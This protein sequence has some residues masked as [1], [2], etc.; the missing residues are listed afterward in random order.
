MAKNHIKVDDETWRRLNSRKEPGD[1]FEEVI[2]RLLEEY[3]E[4]PAGQP[5]DA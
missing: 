5:V 2:R 1:T 4:P 3:D